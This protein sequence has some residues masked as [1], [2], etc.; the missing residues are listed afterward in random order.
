MD[1]QLIQKVE[2]ALNGFETFKTDL[3]AKVD[4]KLDSYD[5]AKLN[6]IADAIG[7]AAEEQQKFNGKLKA[8]EDNQKS[9]E[10]AFNRTR[11][12]KRTTRRP[13]RPSATPCSTSSPACRSAPPRRTS[14]SSSRTA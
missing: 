2:T 7:A 12:A 14:P 9:L 4:A 10:A 1:A 13:S 6:Q 8:I 11:S 5:E 3:A